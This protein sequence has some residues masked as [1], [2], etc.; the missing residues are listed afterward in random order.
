M[1]AGQDFDETVLANLQRLGGVQLTQRILAL[2][3]E[4]TPKRLE[5]VRVGLQEGDL[6]SVERADNSITRHYGGTGLGLTI[7]R[8]LCQLLGYQLMVQS[9]VDK[10]STF[11]ILMPP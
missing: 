6:E 7:S 10:G 5:A 3:L 4:Y 1:T 2:F 8:S 11:S 9:E